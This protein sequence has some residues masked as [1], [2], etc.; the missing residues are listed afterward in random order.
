MKLLD[1]IEALQEETDRLIED[2][3][4]KLPMNL[5][6][7]INKLQTEYNQCN[8]R[9]RKLMDTLITSRK[10]RLKNTKSEQM[11]LAALFEYWKQ[12][13]KRKLNITFAEEKRKELEKELDRIEDMDD[14]LME[15]WGLSKEEIMYS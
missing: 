13:D 5:V 3:D 14:V 15:V 2:P 12:E 10:D 9:Q 8:D 6:E 7:L 1:R 11:N 4:E